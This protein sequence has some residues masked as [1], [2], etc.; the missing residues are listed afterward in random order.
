MF[1]NRFVAL[2]AGAALT[3]GAGTAAA[4]LLPASAG[5]S[6]A[7]HR[8]TGMVN[9]SSAVEK[10]AR[11]TF[12]CNHTTGAYTINFKNVQVIQQD[13]ASRW[14][15]FVV[16]WNIVLPPGNDFDFGKTT[17]VQNSTSG[18]FNAVESGFLTDTAA[19]ATGAVIDGFDDATGG[20]SLKISGT[21]T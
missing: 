3:V 1:R 2:L 19:C 15:T 16:A 13:H 21:L 20:T 11:V 8:Q 5:A 18:L 10:S 17:L 14:S 7:V 6:G 12:Q 4:V 9:N